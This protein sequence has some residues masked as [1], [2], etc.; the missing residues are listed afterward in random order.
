M[1][2]FL[3][4]LVDSGNRKVEAHI[5]LLMLGVL[6]FIALSI[7]HVIVMGR[8]FDPD[9]FGQG[10]GELLAGGGAAAWGQGMQRK[11][12]KENDDESAQ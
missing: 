2:K 8:A 10:L 9:P 6:T 1:K 4:D 11:M 12:E 7:Y 5:V 3:S